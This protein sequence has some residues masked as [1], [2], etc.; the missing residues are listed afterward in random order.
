MKPFSIAID[1]PA[2]AGKSTIAKKLA[3]E[4]GFT[5]VDTGAMYRAITYKAINTLDSLTNEK[6]YTFLE[7]TNIRL[8][9]DKKVYID[10]KDVTDIIREDQVTKNVSTVAALNVVR[11]Y[12]VEIQRKIAS[13]NDVVMDGRD[14]GTTVLPN[15]NIK[16]YLTASVE[17]RA[18]RRYKENIERGI[19]SNL[20]E[21]KQDI[22]NRDIQD[23][24]RVNSPLR[25]AD[26][27][28]EIDSSY[29]T[30]NEVVN[31]IND[32]VQKKGGY[33]MEFDV[34]KVE[35][36][37]IVEGEVVQVNDN[38]IL[39]DIGYMTEG[40]IY[41]NEL[42]MK[43]IKKASEI[44]S[45]GD[46]I[47]VMVK[48][49]DDDE[50]LLS[51]AILERKEL[52]NK[53]QE[54]FKN[55]EVLEGKVVE[56]VNG[57]F[58]VDIGLRAFMPGSHVDVEREF[59]GKTLIGKTINVIVI[60]YKPNKRKSKLVVSR[61]KIQQDELRKKRNE[62][63]NNLKV[64]DIL[65]G[66]VDRIED[67][68][69]IVKLGLIDGLVH[70]SEISHYPHIN[71]REELS[72]GETV[73][74]KVIKINKKQKRIGLSIKA[75]KPTP[76]QLVNEQFEEGQICEGT[77]TRITDFGVFVEM[78]PLVEGLV[79][80]SEVTYN[81]NVDFKTVVSEGENVQVKVLNIDPNRERLSLSFKRVKN[82]PWD[83]LTLNENDIIEGTVKTIIERGA[84]V[85]IV[86]DVEGFLPINQISS[87]KRVSRVEDVLNVGEKVKVKVLEFNKGRQKLVLSIRQIKEDQQ[88]KEVDKYLKEQEG[89][90]STTM[91]DI[92]GD[93]LKGLFKEDK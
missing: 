34:K 67:Y 22:L 33:K 71:I 83:E 30:I 89:Y 28:C 27:A 38:D 54:A 6:K 45:V 16:I 46:K 23:S 87:E 40:V 85:E 4:L 17:E 35:V 81:R 88:R 24:E 50:L 76:W 91:A 19:Q 93:K 5:Y 64:D 42:S 44:V 39:V 3:E 90:E 32:I 82:D 31:K 62:E 73:K 9:S 66:T 10:G 15:A 63:F 61:R 75:L 55:Q 53:V 86:E 65:E 49:C 51:K 13:E 60:E 12:L 20:E 56:A 1:G 92:I 72:I 43:D 29:M 11:K 78:A 79:H 25:K 47:K 36:G 7:N 48:K 52:Q 59:D 70:V 8:T 74:V 68:G 2:G 21:I 69:V 57:G 80:K 18:Q 84:R 58:I 77:V 14:I 41:L 37:S 26:D